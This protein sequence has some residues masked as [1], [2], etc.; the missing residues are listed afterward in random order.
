MTWLMTVAVPA[1]PLCWAIAVAI[2]KKRAQHTRLAEIRALRPTQYRVAPRRITGDRR[3]G[4]EL[5]S[6]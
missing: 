6:S 4:M 5:E 3:V 2:T 1:I